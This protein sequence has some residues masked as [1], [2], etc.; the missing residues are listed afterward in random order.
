MQETRGHIPADYFV[1]TEGLGPNTAVT[2]D[3]IAPRR[4][5]EAPNSAELPE[6]TAEQALGQL[7]V[8][9]VMSMVRGVTPSDG[10]A[11]LQ[12]KPQLYEPGNHAY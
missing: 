4:A 7:H 8:A 9:Q 10:I 12:P 1:Q 3:V 5:I 6:Q 2:R 11:P